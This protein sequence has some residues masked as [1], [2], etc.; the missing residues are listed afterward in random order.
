[1]KTLQPLSEELLYWS[2]E[3]IAD[4]PDLPADETGDEALAAQEETRHEEP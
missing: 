1:M 4:Y 3:T 2:P